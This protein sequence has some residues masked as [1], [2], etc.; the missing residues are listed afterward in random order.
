MSNILK[1]VRSWLFVAF[2]VVGYIFIYSIISFVFS[3]DPSRIYYLI[4][5]AVLFGLFY[6][7]FKYIYRDNTQFNLL[8]A[9]A[10]DQNRVCII[11]SP[12]G[13]VVYA[14]STSLESFEYTL[15]EFT[16]LNHTDLVSTEFKNSQEY[17]ILWWKLILGGEKV[18]GTFIRKNKTGTDIKLAGQYIPILNAEKYITDIVFIS[19]DQ[20]ITHD[21]VRASEFARDTYM[22]HASRILR[23]DLNSGIN[24]YIPRGLKSLIRRLPES[25]IEEYN[26]SVAIK[27]ITAGLKHS[28]QIYKGIREFTNLYKY[29]THLIVKKECS[30]YEALNEYLLDTFY[31]KQVNIDSDL[32]VAT[33]ND[34]LF[35]TAVDNLIRN[36]LTYND[37]TN[38]IVHIYR[39]NDTLVIEDNG[40]GLTNAEFSKLSEPYMRN[41]HQYEHGDGLGLSIC[42]AIIKEHG[43]TINAERTANGTKINIGLK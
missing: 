26:L 40:R 23:H 28:Q 27:L 16:E 6:T 20:T 8:I 30:I 18:S 15:S 25:V 35:C 13:N 14:N 11:F 1:N 42:I 12:N 38:K 43:F 39:N 7:L 29:E 33:I 19:T 5:D 24:I 21:M 4:V 17:K 31:H 22:K 3:L 32:G 34:A 10:F 2:F 9:S 37:S 36:G 41:E